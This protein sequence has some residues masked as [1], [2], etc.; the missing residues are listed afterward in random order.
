MK[1]LE[2]SIISSKFCGEYLC[3]RV[4]ELL[5]LVGAD[6]DFDECGSGLESINFEVGDLELV[7][8]F[9]MCFSAGGPF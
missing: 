9:G 4:L 6:L 7:C 3:R 5:E 8:L 1:R 2:I